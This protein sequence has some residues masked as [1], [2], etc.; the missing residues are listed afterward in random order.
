MKKLASSKEPQPLLPWQMDDARRLAALFEQRQPGV[1][2][3]KKISQLKFGADYDIG[4]QG[5]VW[6]Y[7]TGRRPLNIKAAVNFARGLNELGLKV[8]VEDF[9]PTLAADIKA[10]S[11]QTAKAAPAVSNA[12]GAPAAANDSSWDL[13]D[14][15]ELIAGYGKCSKEDRQAIL[16]FVRDLQQL[17]AAGNIADSTDD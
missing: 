14:V 8:S 3:T 1:A 4:S 12:Y 17:R 5:M 15:A 9:S 6:Q 13:S 10:A 2:K 7:L 11:A 16:D